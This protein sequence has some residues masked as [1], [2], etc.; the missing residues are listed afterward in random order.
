[1]DNATNETARE[2]Y[3]A[4]T[5]EDVPLRAEE[6]LLGGCKI[7]PQGGPNTFICGAGGSPCS[8]PG[9]S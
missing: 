1:M 4:P 9:R 5:I 2:P 7:P 3:E 8:A 6:Q